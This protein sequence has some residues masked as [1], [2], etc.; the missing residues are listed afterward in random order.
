MFASETS[1]DLTSPEVLEQLDTLETSPF[2]NEFD[3]LP[4]DLASMV[5]LGYE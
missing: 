5:N 1:E 4:H 3:D 2:F